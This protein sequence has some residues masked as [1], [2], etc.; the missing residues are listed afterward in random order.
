[1]SG[2][3][4]ESGTV[5]SNGE[6]IK[7]VLVN[8]KPFFGDD[9]NVALKN[10]PAEV[11]NKIQV[12]DK[13]SDQAQLTGFDD[14]NAVRTMN[15]ITRQGFNNSKFGKF[16]GGYGTNDWYLAGGNLNF[17][18]NERRISVIGLFNNVNQQNFSIQ[19]LLGVIGNSSQRRGGQGGQR[20]DQSRGRG[21]HH[22]VS[23]CICLP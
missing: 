5:K 8:D 9:P 23:Q 19:D 14:G 16:Y 4:V 17:F 18:K 3:T 15:I 7:Q 20:F 13:M 21:D 12:F 22:S 10:L 11:I 1:M 2:I 6:N